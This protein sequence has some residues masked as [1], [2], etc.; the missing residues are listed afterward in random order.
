MSTVWPSETQPGVR[1]RSLVA[2]AIRRG[3][4]KREPCVKCGKPK[5]EGHHEDYAKPLEVIWLCR[6]H[7]SWVHKYG[8][9]PLPGQDL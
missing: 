9:S 3:E 6:L 4:L 1:A 8:D 5:T 2:R 7:H